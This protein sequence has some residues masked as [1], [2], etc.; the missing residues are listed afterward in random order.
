M[1]QPPSG[2]A[3]MSK[4]LENQYATEQNFSAEDMAAYA[5]HI[6]QNSHGNSILHQQPC[7][8]PPASAA[9]G[10]QQ[11]I[12]V[13]RNSTEIMTT[14]SP[15]ATS[16]QKPPFVAAEA[17]IDVHAPITPTVQQLKPVTSE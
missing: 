8:V 16:T 12:P 14:F 4:M 17:K 9:A 13:V 11:S 7:P 6:L 3:A 15:L 1:I 10:S 2:L 5:G